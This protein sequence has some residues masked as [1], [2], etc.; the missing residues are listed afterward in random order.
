MDRFQGSVDKNTSKCIYLGV[1]T[2]FASASSHQH[3]L[4]QSFDSWARGE[5]EQTLFFPQDGAL[6]RLAHLYIAGE[7]IKNASWQ[8]PRVTQLVPGRIHPI[9]CHRHMSPACSCIPGS[10]KPTLETPIWK[11]GEWRVCSYLNV[12]ADHWSY[13]NK[14]YTWEEN[15]F[16]FCYLTSQ[17]SPFDIALLQK[18]VQ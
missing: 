9:K 18:E 3:Q 12:S 16:L 2:S 11:S 1:L 10:V 14:P 4:T 7:C 6:C 17:M 15:A 13:V 8:P 5:A